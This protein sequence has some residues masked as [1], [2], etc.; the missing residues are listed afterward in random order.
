MYMQLNEL[1]GIGEKRLQQL[2]EAGIQD[3]LALLS[4]F[5]KRVLFFQNAQAFAPQTGQGQLLKVVVHSPAKVMFIKKN[6]NATTCLVT[7]TL[8]QKKL[9]L[10]WY[11]QPYMKNRLIVGQTYYVYGKPSP[12][13]QN[14][15]LV[16]ILQTEEKHASQPTSFT[17]YKPIANMGNAF[18]KSLIQ[19]ALKQTNISSIMPPNVE[20]SYQCMPLQTAYTNMHFPKTEEEYMQAKQR[21]FIEQILYILSLKLQIS[22]KESEK[23]YKFRE[24]NQIFANF[25]KLLPY[26]LTSGQTMAITQIANDCLSNHPMNRLLEGDTGCGKT[27]VAMFACYFAMKNGYQAAIMAPTELLA[28]QHFQTAQ[29]LF[30]KQHRI[31]YLHSGLKTAEKRKLLAGIRIGFYELVIGTHAIISH[32]VEYACL[33]MVIT[34]EQHRFGVRTRAQLEN[35]GEEPETL[36]MSATPIPRSLSLVMYG[37]LSITQIHERPHGESKTQTHLIPTQKIPAMWQFIRQQLDIGK[38]AFVVC[39]RVEDAET[40]DESMQNVT[41]LYK[42]LCTSGVF[43]PTKIGLIHGKQTLEKNLEMIDQFKQNTYNLL[44]AT[45]IVEVGIDI[46]DASIIVITNPERFGLATLHQLRGRV[47]RNGN[48]AYCFLTCENVTEQNIERLQYFQKHNDGFMLAEYDFASRGGGTILGTKQHG[49]DTLLQGIGFH[50]NLLSTAEQ[51]FNDL[52]T[53]IDMSVVQQRAK[54]MYEEIYNNIVLN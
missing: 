44:V 51:I 36:V 48:L 53:R 17:F 16:Q 22:K 19:Q 32:K 9:T 28:K 8:S 35:K 50:T 26:K 5:P 31:C 54:Q 49:K 4:Y 52:K 38:K 24:F 18:I 43:E 13:K 40:E 20:Q 6:F 42:Q 34:D 46:P 27:M 45:T 47:G 11:N 25:Q 12:T 2:R 1:K 3:T 37:D 10:T 14:T 23:H 33:R 21:I 7:D 15:L 30:G 41:A 39:P 29:T